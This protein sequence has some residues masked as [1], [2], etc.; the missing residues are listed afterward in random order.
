MLYD[1]GGAP[2]LNNGTASW[3]LP[4]PFA[5]TPCGGASCFNLSLRLSEDTAASGQRVGGWAVAGCFAADLCAA[6]G[7]TPLTDK[8]PTPAA[9]AIGAR[10]F[11]H[12]TASVAAPA[13]ALTALRFTVA[14]AYTW[15][16]EGGAPQGKQALV[17]A[18]AAL[19]DWSGAARCVPPGCHLAAY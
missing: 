8:L 1:A 2:P 3:V 17:L 7:W 12:V 10:R 14:S 15:G 16:G 13:A 6:G 19:F 18:S 4:A 11:V 5:G 9:T